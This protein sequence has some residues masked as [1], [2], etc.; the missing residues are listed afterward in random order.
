LLLSPKVDIITLGLVGLYDKAGGYTACYLALREHLG[1]T[2]TIGALSFFYLI[3][4][5]LIIPENK[6]NC[7]LV[8]ATGN[9]YSSPSFIPEFLN[10]LLFSYSGVTYMSI[11]GGIYLSAIAHSPS[12]S[13]N[14]L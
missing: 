1:H 10:L 9:F 4:F 12:P 3:L 2:Q 5:Y 6:K 8:L 14:S 13:S 11:K 7:S